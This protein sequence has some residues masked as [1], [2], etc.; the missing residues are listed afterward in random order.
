MLYVPKF[1]L[2]LLEFLR[3]GALFWKEATLLAC[4]YNC[5]WVASFFFES[6]NTFFGGDPKESWMLVISSVAGCFLCCQEKMLFAYASVLKFDQH[7][8]H[9]ATTTQATAT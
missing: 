8:N 6:E 3:I 1:M 9:D 4:M 7:I 5:K 2:H